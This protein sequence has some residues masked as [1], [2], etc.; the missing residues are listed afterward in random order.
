MDGST[1]LVLKLY[2]RKRSDLSTG[3]RNYLSLFDVGQSS[4]STHARF[5]TEREVLAL[6]QR[7]GFDVPEVYSPAFLAG[8][9][10]P[11]TAME[12][13]PGQTL[14]KLIH[15]TT[16]PL[17]RK[18]EV[19]SRFCQEMAGR[20]ERALGRQEVRLLLFHPN[21]SRILV[22]NDRLV[23]L[24]FEVVYTPKTDL[25][26]IAGKEIAGF[27]YALARCAPR[28]QLHS[29][30]E[31]FIKAYPDKARMAFVLEEL[32]RFGTIPVYGW[33]KLFPFMFSFYSKVPKVY[34]IPQ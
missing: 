16:I 1:P 15:D 4:F 23:Y 26:R 24:D 12:W 10:Q 32:R 19:I 9:D 21:L 2:G 18:K 25:E 11:C 22:S 28:Q 33:L 31:C 7:E 14:T 13:I 34:S 29:L 27:L 5:Q 3:L 6:W 20:H 8:F 30:M 17:D